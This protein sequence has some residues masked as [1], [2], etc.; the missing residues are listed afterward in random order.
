M[1]IEFSEMEPDAKFD[2]LTR[3]LAGTVDPA[4]S[5]GFTNYERAFFS[6]EFQSYASHADLQ[7]TEKLK[8]LM[9]EQMPILEQLMILHGELIQQDCYQNLVPLHEQLTRKFHQLKADIEEKYGRRA[10]HRYFEK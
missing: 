2:Q 7:N 5:G 6:A 4:V 8:T 9:S 10:R 3:K 1:T